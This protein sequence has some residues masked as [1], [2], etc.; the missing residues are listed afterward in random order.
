MWRQFISSQAFLDM[1]FGNSNSSYTSLSPNRG[2]EIEST[3]D[4]QLRVYRTTYNI[5]QTT[6]WVSSRRNFYLKKKTDFV[7]KSFLNW[8]KNSTI[9]VTLIYTNVNNEIVLLCFKNIISF[10]KVY[11]VSYICTNLNKYF[12]KLKGE[13]ELLVKKKIVDKLG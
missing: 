1:T 8:N 7:I 12:P 11:G 2:I 9:E 6:L 10:N 4:I 3:G 13:S 5:H